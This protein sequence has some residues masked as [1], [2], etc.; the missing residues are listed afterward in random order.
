MEETEILEDEVLE[1]PT[2][3]V[4][5]IRNIEFADGS[6]LEVEVNAT[7]FI[8]DEKPDIP[9]YAENVT[10]P[11]MDGEG[12]RS[13]AHAKFQECYGDDSRFWFTYVEIPEDEIWKNKIQSDIDYIAMMADVELEE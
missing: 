3:R 4:P 5:I 10:V 9:E 12:T 6:T 1:E 7:T 13:I 2:E 8:T 11:D